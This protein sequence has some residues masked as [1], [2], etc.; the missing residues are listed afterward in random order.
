MWEKVW[1]A[2]NT[3]FRP[4]ISDCQ[5]EITSFSQSDGNLVDKRE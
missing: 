4:A 3:V 5:S 2:C 1:D